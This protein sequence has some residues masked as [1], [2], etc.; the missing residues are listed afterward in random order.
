[1]LVIG[2]IVYLDTEQVMI[3]P[4][5]LMRI[6]TFHTTLAWRVS[7]D[8]PSVKTVLIISHLSLA[9]LLLLTMLMRFN[10]GIHAGLML[11]HGIYLNLSSSNNVC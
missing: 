4:W 10:M 8:Y 11:C 3:E 9:I 6:G 7:E 2:K 1:M 5:K